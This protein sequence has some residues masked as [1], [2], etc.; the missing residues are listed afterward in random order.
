MNQYWRYRRSS[1]SQSFKAR[2]VIVFK[3]LELGQH[4]DHRRH[5]YRMRHVFALDGLTKGLRTK[6]RDRGLTSTESRGCEHEGKVR[7]VKYRCCVKVHTTL[8]I[9]HPVV[10]VVHIRQDVCVSQ[11]HPFG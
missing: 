2:E 10:G 1:I 11:R 7:N 9:T 4:I 6:L 5:Q 8:S 3:F